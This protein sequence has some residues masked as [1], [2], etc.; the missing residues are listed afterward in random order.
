MIVAP[1]RVTV[2]GEVDCYQRAAERQGDG[3]PGVRVLC[4][5]VDEH[6]VGRLVTPDQGADAAPVG[7]GDGLPAHGRLP[8]PGQPG[9]ACVLIEQAELVVG[10][11]PNLR[12]RGR[13]LPPKAR[14]VTTRLP[15]AALAS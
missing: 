15:P 11:L 10:H 7:K 4:P 8:R 9:L 13:Q 1:V 12:R 6:H 5:P 2:A 3:V 14:S